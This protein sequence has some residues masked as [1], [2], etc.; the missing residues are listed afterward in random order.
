MLGEFRSQFFVKNHVP[1]S[2]VNKKHEFLGGQNT[3]KIR[4]L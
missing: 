2:S 3:K 1:T 4:L